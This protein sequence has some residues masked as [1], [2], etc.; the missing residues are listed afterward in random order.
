MW[1]H[2]VVPEAWPQPIIFLKT[3]TKQFTWGQAYSGPILPLYACV[4]GGVTKEGVMRI[5]SIPPGVSQF[6]TI[7]SSA[8]QGEI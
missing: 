6:C 4:F 1:I 5:G 3:S 7:I 8:Y 2:A